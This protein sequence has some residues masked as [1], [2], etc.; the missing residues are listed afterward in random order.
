MI[1]LKNGE[2]CIFKTGNDITLISYIERKDKYMTSFLMLASDVEE[3]EQYIGQA[4]SWSETFSDE[5][6]KIDD[7]NKEDKYKLMRIIYK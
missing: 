5:I 4:V 7:L 1:D 6:T 2:L 3:Y